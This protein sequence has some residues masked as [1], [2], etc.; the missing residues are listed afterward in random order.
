[1]FFGG[2]RAVRVACGILVPRL[3]IEPV[4]SA[5]EVWSLNHW[6]AREVLFPPSKLNVYPLQGIL[7]LS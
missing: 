6:I 7:F 5:M 4:P 1:M 2:G 3:G